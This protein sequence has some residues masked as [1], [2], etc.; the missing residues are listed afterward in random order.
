MDLF[1][2]MDGQLER[3]KYYG[4]NFNLNSPVDLNALTPYLWQCNIH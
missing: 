3:L 1:A 4:N 2:G